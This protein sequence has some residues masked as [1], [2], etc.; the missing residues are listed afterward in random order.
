MSS[1]A[2]GVQNEMIGLKIAQEIVEESS[3][4]N[5][6]AAAEDIGNDINAAADD[7]DDD[8]DVADIEDEEAEEEHYRSPQMQWDALLQLI[9]TRTNEAMETATAAAAAVAQTQDDKEQQQTW[10]AAEH[11]AHYRATFEALRE[12]VASRDDIPD[13]IATPP[14]IRRLRLVFCPARLAGRCPCCLD[15]GYGLPRAVVGVGSGGD[16]HASPEVGVGVTKDLLLQGLRDG[17][18]PDV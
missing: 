3:P 9:A 1:A 12:E 16:D 11:N 5:H 13:A 10:T 2:E 15:G 7:D 17:L 6:Q 18:F 8:D 14:G 4:R